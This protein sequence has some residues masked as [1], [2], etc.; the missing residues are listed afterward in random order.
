MAKYVITESLYVDGVHHY[1]TSERPKVVE[2]PDKYVHK[3]E[4]GKFHKEKNR[5]LKP[6]ESGEPEGEKLAKHFN[7]GPKGAHPVLG[8]SPV[9]TEGQAGRGHETHL[10]R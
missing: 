10:T 8:G 3:D 1:A 2:V 9:A 4:Q 7:D 5:H 6:Y